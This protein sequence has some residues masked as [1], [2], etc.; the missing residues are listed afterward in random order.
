M[1]RSLVWTYLDG[2][3][4]VCKRASSCGGAGVLRCTSTCRP[5]VCSQVRVNLWDLAGAADYLEVRNEFYKDAQVRLHACGW[6]RVCAC[7]RTV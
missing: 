2:A 4:V 7:V 3:A 5:D 6:M 1:Q